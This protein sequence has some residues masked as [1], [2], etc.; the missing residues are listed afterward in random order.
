M[1]DFQALCNRIND[2]QDQLERHHIH[3]EHINVGGGLGIDYQHPNRVPM[4]DF[5]SYF[6][7]YAKRLKL[8][9]GQTLHFELGRA[10]L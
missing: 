5:K 4:A 6:S 2:L 7:T 9:N 8:R 10:V 1:G 3:V